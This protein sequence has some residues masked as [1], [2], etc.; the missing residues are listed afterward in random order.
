MG[1][2]LYEK[3]GQSYAM[4][5]AQRGVS[6]RE[7]WKQSGSELSFESWIKAQSILPSS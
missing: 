5:P 7:L 3:R 1:R 6:Y 2:K 4:K